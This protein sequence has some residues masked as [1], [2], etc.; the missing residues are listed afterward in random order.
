MLICEL[1][2][3]PSHR[4]MKSIASSGKSMF[5]DFNRGYAST[6]VEFSA[7]ITYHKIN[8]DCQSW[9]HDNTLASPNNPNTNC[10]WIITREIGSYIT[11]VFSFIEVKEID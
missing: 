4:I 2:G 10:S 3:T 7:S 1:F 8:P 9:L 11:L 5:I 6:I